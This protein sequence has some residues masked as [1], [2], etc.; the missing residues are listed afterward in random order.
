[1]NL[2]FLN[3]E[4]DKIKV[5]EE[6]LTFKYEPRSRLNQV[7]KR[8]NTNTNYSDNQKIFEDEKNKKENSSINKRK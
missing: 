2:N 7:N 5:I 4:F 3:R 8:I 1:M 6:F